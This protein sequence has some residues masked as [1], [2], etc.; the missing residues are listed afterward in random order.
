MRSAD[1]PDPT[2]LGFMVSAPTRVTA[3]PA[4]CVHAQ[5]SGSPSGSWLLSPFRV[6][7]AGPTGLIS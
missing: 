6:T 7:L 4:T 5:L 3:G 1:C 2:K